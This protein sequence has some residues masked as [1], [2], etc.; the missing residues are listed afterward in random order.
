MELTVGQKLWFVPGYNYQ[1]F[2]VEVV[3]IGRRWATVENYMHRAIRIDIETMRPHE[4]DGNGLCYL[5]REDY[6][7]KQA[8]GVAW[9]NLC[10]D[11][12]RMYRTPDGVT[13]E[14]IAAARKLLGL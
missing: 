6:E 13:V 14:K 12:S 1:P 7:T 4:N 5:S 9:R 8:L 2:D 11:I 3:K 10:S